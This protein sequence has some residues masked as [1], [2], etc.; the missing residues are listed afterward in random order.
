[1]YSHFLATI[2]IINK[3]LNDFDRERPHDPI[4]AKHRLMVWFLGMGAFV[5]I[6]ILITGIINYFQGLEF[7]MGGF[8][9]MGG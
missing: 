5:F 2:P 8:M 9:A 3:I 1:M 6:L 4:N 7:D